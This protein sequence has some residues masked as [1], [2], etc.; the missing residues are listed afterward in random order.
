[1]IGSL[2]RLS[3]NGMLFAEAAILVHL[4]AIRIVLL[5]FHRVVVALLA[6]RA[7]Q[8]DLHSHNG[9]SM[10]LE[11]DKPPSSGT[12]RKKARKKITPYLRYS[13]Y[14]TLSAVGQVFF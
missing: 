12:T 11:I 9:T 6:F 13:K 2:L 10:F 5:V 4:Q 3:V 8:S 14:T 7:S 1:M